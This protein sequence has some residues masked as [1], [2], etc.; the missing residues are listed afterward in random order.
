MTTSGLMFA[1]DNFAFA[2]DAGRDP[3]QF[4]G[5]IRSKCAA[6]FSNLESPFTVA[7]ARARHTII[8]LK[9]D[10]GQA[11]Y[12][13]ESGRFDAVTIANNHVADYGAEGLTETLR[14]L[15]ESGIAHAG[16]GLAVEQALEPAVV[17]VEGLRVAI[18]GFSYSGRIK[19]P[20]VFVTPLDLRSA[21]RSIGR[22]RK[23][24]ADFIVCSPHWGLEYSVFP[25][26]KQQ[27]F[28][29]GL[30]D[31]GADL[32]V[33]HHPHVI[34]GAEKYKGRSI[35]YSLGNFNMGDDWTMRPK[36]GRYGAVLLVDMQGKEMG[37]YEIVP[38]RINEHFQPVP[39]S[40][41]ARSA[42]D[43]I[44]KEI[45]EP[46][47]GGMSWGYWM[48]RAGLTAFRARRMAWRMGL[49]RRANRKDYWL[50]RVRMAAHFIHPTRL[51]W[52]LWARLCAMLRPGD[53]FR[54]PDEL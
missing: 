38:V 31:R 27:A 32:V 17:D 50:G 15:D 20:G 52:G 42:F 39:V 53:I 11:K 49:R 3:Y 36:F 29:R 48:R 4:V 25:T 46:L 22:A 47:G 13:K 35:F 7:Q 45:S 34:Q 23:L 24:G 51:L 37:G 12:L 1:G 44:F 30:I 8:N 54:L 41:E 28:G 33:G 26:P 5:E 19:C 21:E 14:S 18:I 40:G 43:R 2:G 9:I 10:P 16:A 6:A